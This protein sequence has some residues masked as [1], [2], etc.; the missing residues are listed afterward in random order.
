MIFLFD[1]NFKELYLSRLNKSM[2]S[3]Y[4]M[5]VAGIII[6]LAALP[7]LYLD[8]SVRT[9]GIIRPLQER[10]EIKATVS[11]VIEKIYFAESQLV[12][13]GA[14]ILRI[15]DDKTGSKKTQSRFEI[16]Q[17]QQFIHD[18][19]LLSAT[20]FVS[21]KIYNALVSPLYKQQL[22]RFL[23]QQSGHISTLEK[24]NLELNTDSLLAAERV[25]APKEFMD[26]KAEHEKMLSAFEAFRQEQLSTWQQ[27]LVKYRLELSQLQS[28][29]HQLI[30][31]AGYY[32]VKAPVGGTLQG[33]HSKYAGGLLEAG[34][35]VGTLS[36]E[37]ELVAEC[38]VPT[39]DAGLLIKDQE[40]KFQI[41]AFDYN[42]FGIATGKL[43]SIDNDFTLIENQP[44]FKVRCAFDKKQLHLKN[45]F[46]G[47]LKK[48]LTVQARFIIA[49][50]SLWQL[51]F[52]K[53]DDWANPSKT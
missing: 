39:R 17:R 16:A 6:V 38:Y 44:V 45:G 30:Q 5:I 15:K 49:N 3:I 24:I 36:P 48:G 21:Q 33:I 8:V 7:F 14:V 52:D 13:E 34:E 41:D 11:G 18:L 32:E 2:L 37:T 42:Y 43:I 28:L 12:P 9:T 10:T 51:L 1:V 22:S 47:H 50:R 4:W 27:E 35:T 19:E 26:K 31:E 40:V 53:L 46:T 23:F 20:D 25:I 29:Q